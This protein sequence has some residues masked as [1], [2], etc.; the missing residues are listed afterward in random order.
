MGTEG[1]VII[2]YSLYP[3]LARV[4]LDPK[5]P[6]S[7]TVPVTSNVYGPCMEY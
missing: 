2:L 4:Q 5:I 3:V 1:G 6:K 7:A